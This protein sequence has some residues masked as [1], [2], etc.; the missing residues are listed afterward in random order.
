[1]Y[2]LLVLAFA[3]GW[4]RS[5]D[6]HVGLPI[7][8]IAIGIGTT[9]RRNV[10]VVVAFRNEEH[11]L[12]PL[13][14]DLSALDYPAELISFILVDDHSDDRSPALVE[15]AT[16]TDNRI[17]LLR[18]PSDLAGKKSAITY[19][20]NHTRAEVIMTT[21]ADCRLPRNWITLTNQGF[22]TATCRMIVGPVRLTDEN[23]FQQIQAMEFAS[24][25]GTAGATLSIGIAGTCNGANL[26]FLRESFLEVRGYDGN[27]SISSGDDEFLM[28]KFSRQWNSSVRF[29]HH[30]DAVV[31]ARASETLTEF[32]RQRLRWAGKWKPGFSSSSILAICILVFHVV[33]I[34]LITGWLAGAFST[35]IFA[36]LA[37]AK[38]F[39]EVIFLFP[40]CSFLKVRRRWTSFLALQFIYSFYVISIGIVSQILTTRWKGREVVTRVWTGIA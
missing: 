38:L 2:V 6:N 18:L 7:V 11:S 5:A 31:T 32:V 9:L 28:K 1:L 16:L 21:D 24:L 36:C 23:F 19:A 33:N 13:L 10:T 30:P 39:A 4:A 14:Q 3:F 15:N 8:P 20:I 40:V 35:V 37:G 27:E 17:R 34:A 12:G 26:A 25:I 22:S 29:L